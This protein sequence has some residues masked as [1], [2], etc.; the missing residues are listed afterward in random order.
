MPGFVNLELD[1]NINTGRQVELHQ[2]I[3]GLGGRI[4]NVEHALV[5]TDFELL[6]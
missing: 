4:D 3:D 1:L 2:S 5:G 6:A